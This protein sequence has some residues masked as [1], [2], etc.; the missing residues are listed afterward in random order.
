VFSPPPAELSRSAS[1]FLA[2][3]QLLYDKPKIRAYITTCTVKRARAQLFPSLYP[4]PGGSSGSCRSGNSSTHPLYDLAILLKFDSLKYLAVTR[5]S[6]LGKQQRRSLVQLTQ[7][8]T[9]TA[10]VLPGAWKRNPLIVQADKDITLATL[11]LL[12][13]YIR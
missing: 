12:P 9:H 7:R 5:G 13:T 4:S 8:K 6:P 1:D 11:F 10:S 2:C 3:R